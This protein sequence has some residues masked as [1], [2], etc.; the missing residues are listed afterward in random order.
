MQKEYKLSEEAA[1]DQMQTLMDS[2]DIDQNDLVVDQGPE[3]VETILNRLVRAIRSGTIEILDGGVV[4]HNLHVPMGET[5]S[6]TYG[7]LNGL[8]MKARDKAKGGF[9]KD[10]ALMGSLG[11]VPANAMAKLDPVD[12]SIFQRLGTLFMVV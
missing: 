12:I 9:E 11:N 7:R 6:I 3:A 8:A 1:R 10:C 5:D 4:K 2:Y